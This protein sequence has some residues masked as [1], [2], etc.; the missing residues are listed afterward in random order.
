MIPD[1]CDACENRPATYLTAKG[2]NRGGTTMHHERLKQ[3]HCQSVEKARRAGI[4][5]Y[6]LDGQEG[7]LRV[8][9]DGRKDRIVVAEGRPVIQ[10]V[11]RARILSASLG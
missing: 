1:A 7:V 9:P 5:A 3:F 2:V 8:L 4:T 10:P 11:A 6:L